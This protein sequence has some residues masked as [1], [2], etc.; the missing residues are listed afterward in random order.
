MKNCRKF[1]VSMLL[2]LCTVL[3]TGC[4]GTANRNTDLPEVR[5]NGTAI[6]WKYTN[7]TEWHD[8]VT[9]A[10]LMGAMGEKGVDGINGKDGLD[11]KDGVD[12][13]TIE[14]QRADSH[15]QWRYEGGEWQ[16]LVALAAISGPAGQSG[17][18]GI[19]GKTPE[20]RVNESTLQ[21][22]YTDDE[23]W[24]NLYD[25]S[26]LR[27]LD[28]KDG[29]DGKDGQDGKDGSCAGYFYASNHS[30]VSFDEPLVLWEK[31]NSGE[32]IDW[33]LNQRTVTLKKG[34]TY[35]ITFSGSF[36]IY[37][38][39]SGWYAAGLQDGFSKE[40]DLN[41]Y[42]HMYTNDAENSEVWVPFTLDYICKAEDD[43]VLKYSFRKMTPITN[44]KGANYSLTIIA[45]D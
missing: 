25:L 41:T 13:K 39:T 23:V 26:V 32:L 19:N 12:G 33:N 30:A 20:F 8:L 10:E 17:A 34:H 44:I 1:F 16:N 3:A 4:S 43:I 21:W 15:I 45:L 14:V 28:G 40:S 18:D 24:L 7:E 35:S 37:A 29:I 22:R 36:G 11:G 9:L 31:I 5:N 38:E 2:A 6:Q 27:G 42:V